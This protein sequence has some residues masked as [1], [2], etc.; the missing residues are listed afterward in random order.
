[1]HFS[2]RL[3]FSLFVPVVICFPSLGLSIQSSW[4]WLPGKLGWS[5][6]QQSGEQSCL[7]PPAG[8]FSP[9]KLPL[10]TPRLFIWEQGSFCVAFFALG[11]QANFFFLIVIIASQKSSFPILT[12]PPITSRQTRLGAGASRLEQRF[13]FRNFFF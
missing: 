13:R 12:F 11:I 7:S 10:P 9:A 3:P 2:L 5:M 4:G 6:A 1:M 8:S